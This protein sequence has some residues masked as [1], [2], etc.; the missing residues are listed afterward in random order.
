MDDV[1]APV[2]EP[3]G[4]ADVLVEPLELAKRVFKMTHAS[5]KHRWILP[6]GF[7]STAVVEVCID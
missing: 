6:E 7:P 3:F 1:I 2:A 5:V 4:D